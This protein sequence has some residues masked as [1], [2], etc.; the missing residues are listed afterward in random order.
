MKT[1][2]R[3]VDV[4]VQGETLSNR[5]A[6]AAEA[7]TFALYH[8]TGYYASPAIERIY[9][10]AAAT[11]PDVACK[12]VKGTVLHVMTKAY[13]SG[14]HTRVVQRWME[15]SKAGERHSVVF[16]KQENEPVPAW[17]NEAAKGHGGELIMFNETDDIICALRLRQ[18]AAKYERIVLHVHM[19]DPIAL[20]AF[21]V[22]SFTTPIIYFNHA[23]HLFWLGVSVADIVADLRYDNF[24]YK[25]R[26]VRQSYVLGIP[27]D[28][29]VDNRFADRLSTRRELRMPENGQV[30]VTTGSEYKYQPI[31]SNCLCKQLIEIVKKNDNVTCYAIGPSIE[32]REW[33]WANEV[34]MGKIQPLGVVTNKDLYRK[35][36]QAADLYIGSYP[37]GGYTSMMDAVQCGLPFI[38][39]IMTRQQ[40]SILCLRPDID[41]SRC[42]CYSTNELVN[43]TL[44]VLSGKKEYEELLASSLEWVNDYADQARWQKRLYDMYN[45]CASK[46]TIHK[47]ECIRGKQVFIDD[48]HCLMQLMHT[49]NDMESQRK[50]LRRMAER[51]L[52]G[53]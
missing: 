18:L 42:L 17:L 21:G 40:K 4:A 30:I 31:G 6:K 20:I 3:M 22:E 29:F 44:S 34:T 27:C 13:A 36:L 23:D 50:M 43:K 12:P 37:Y 8:A 45:I 53:I 15:L 9:L 35:Y 24:S 38:Q 41:Q 25:R 5:M 46:H 49:K 10:E 48:E 14:G 19:N 47:F 52:A 16:L 26:D 28:P 39:L 11:I 2:E 32:S 7:V 51:S 33:K 1:F